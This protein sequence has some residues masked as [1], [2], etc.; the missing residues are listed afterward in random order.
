VTVL[1]KDLPQTLGKS[2]EAWVP[3]SRRRSTGSGMSSMWE[4]RV[5]CER[6]QAVRTSFGAS[7]DVNGDQHLT[8]VDALRVINEL[9]R[10][11][12]LLDAGE[13]ESDTAGLKRY[14]LREVEPVDPC[15]R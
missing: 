13:G 3:L 7:R 1:T 6:Y 12:P 15:W 4:R 11:K 10:Q 8:P 14:L 9:V 5:S 2:P